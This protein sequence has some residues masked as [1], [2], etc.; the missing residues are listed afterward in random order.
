MAS[1]RVQFPVHRQQGREVAG[2]R[3]R[4]RSVQGFGQRLRLLAARR[5]RCQGLVVVQPDR[6]PVPDAIPDGGELVLNPLAFGRP[7]WARAAPRT[8]S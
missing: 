3:Q 6:L 1:D 4:F 7:C 2:L 5:G 8:L